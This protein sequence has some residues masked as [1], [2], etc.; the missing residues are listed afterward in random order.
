MILNKNAEEMI[1]KKNA[2]ERQDQIGI[3]KIY[4]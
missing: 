4:A 2:E 1:Q 3:K